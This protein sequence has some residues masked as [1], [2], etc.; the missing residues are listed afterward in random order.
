[1]DDE[2]LEKVM[3]TYQDVQKE[4]KADGIV[5]ALLTLAVIV[6]G[7]NESIHEVEKVVDRGLR[8]VG[9]AVSV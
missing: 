9:D 7:M 1:M 5:A 3:G 2:I 6:E 8:D 4:I